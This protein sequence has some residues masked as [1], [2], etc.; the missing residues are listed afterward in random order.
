LAN[1][2]TSF[3]EASSRTQATDPNRRETLRIR[4]PLPGL[5]GEAKWLRMRS[6]VFRKHGGPRYAVECQS[7]YERGDSPA[8]GVA[9]RWCLSAGVMRAG[10]RAP[11]T[12]GG[13]RWTLIVRAEVG[14][15]RRCPCLSLA[16]ADAPY[17]CPL[18]NARLPA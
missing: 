4:T 9:I 8:F 12:K 18:I 1:L 5:R 10:A 13:V 6:A 11:R 16:H 7:S 3:G 17:A 15:T 14:P 2:D